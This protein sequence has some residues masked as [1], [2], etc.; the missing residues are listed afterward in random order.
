VARDRGSTTEDT[1]EELM[2]LV[3]GEYRKG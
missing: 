2:K 1:A 3:A